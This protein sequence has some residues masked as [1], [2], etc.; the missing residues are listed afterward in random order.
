MEVAFFV[1]EDALKR[2]QPNVRFD[3]TGLL[4]AF[5]LNRERIHATAVKMYR[6]GRKGSYDLMPGDF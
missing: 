6:R 1:Y 2:I 5:D 4:G 3:E